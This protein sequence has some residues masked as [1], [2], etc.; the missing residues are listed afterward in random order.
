MM[1]H[2]ATCDSEKNSAGKLSTLGL[3]IRVYRM[4]GVRDAGHPP[5]H[6]QQQHE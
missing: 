6:I 4:P 2:G 3:C 1:H 5:T